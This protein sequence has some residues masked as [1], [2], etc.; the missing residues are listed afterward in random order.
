MTSP[1]RCTFED[2]ELNHLR[3]ALALSHAQRWQWLRE[4]M[5]FGFSVA[6]QRAEQGLTTLGPNGDV[7]W[8]PELQARLKVSPRSS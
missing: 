2:A 4:A 5:D 7:L 3:D 1:L 8:S 6:Q